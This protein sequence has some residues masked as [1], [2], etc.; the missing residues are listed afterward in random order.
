MRFFG[1]S[2]IGVFLLAVT[3]G[4]LAFAGQV[5]FSAV[6]SRFADKGPGMPARERE[7]SASV[8]RVEPG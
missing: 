6:Q 1:R 5:V 7:F 2:L 4:I 3:L 8:M